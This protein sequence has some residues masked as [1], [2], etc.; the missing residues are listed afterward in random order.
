MSLKSEQTATRRQAILWWIEHSGAHGMSVLKLRN[1]MVLSRESIKY[2]LDRL[3]DDGSITRVGLSSAT[4]YA[5]PQHAA[6]AARTIETRG[7]IT[8]AA[9]RQR[10][11]D[12]MRRSRASRRATRSDATD[13]DEDC[14]PFD[15]VLRGVGEW[16]AK[17][18]RGPVS[19]FD[20]GVAS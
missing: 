18:V 7:R 12:N 19:V 15:H 1:V 9:R 17:P 14:R 5:M 16:K 20:L 10:G 11:L 6:D 3:L 13:S 4:T 8:A 2:I